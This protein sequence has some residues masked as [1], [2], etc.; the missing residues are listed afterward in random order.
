[1]RRQI[2]AACLLQY[3]FVGKDTSSGCG[4]GKTRDAPFLSSHPSPFPTSELTPFGADGPSPAAADSA[5]SFFPR[6]LAGLPVE[7]PE[8]RS[9]AIR[10][11]VHE[12]RRHFHNIQMYKGAGPILRPPEDERDRNCTRLQKKAKDRERDPSIQKKKET[13]IEGSEG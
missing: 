9:A 2:V 10:F 6:L 4:R 13:K 5:L 11:R 8:S 12:A 7:W 3:I 1:M